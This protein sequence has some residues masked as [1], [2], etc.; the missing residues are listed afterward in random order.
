MGSLP[1]CC[2]CAR[3]ASAEEAFFELGDHSRLRGA[4][5]VMATRDDDTIR[6]PAC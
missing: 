6:L 3:A 1:C 5:D 2:G 4:V